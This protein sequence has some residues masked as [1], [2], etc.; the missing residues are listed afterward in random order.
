MRERIK[1]SPSAKIAKPR[2]SPTMTA[3]S[4][5]QRFSYTFTLGATTD[6]RNIW[7]S[8]F[9]RSTGANLQIVDFELYTGSS[10]LGPQVLAGHLYPGAHAYDTAPSYSGGVLDLT[11]SAFGAIQF[12]TAA[13][14][15]TVTAMAVA[16]KT[17]TGGS[18]FQVLLSKIQNYSDFLFETDQGGAAAGNLNDAK[19]MAQ[20]AGIY[21]PAGMGWHT[22]TLR[23]DGTYV[24]LFIDDVRLLR[25]TA[26]PSGAIS[27][28]DMFVNEINAAGLYGNL[29]FNSIA[30]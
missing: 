30:L 9:D 12:G 5:W 29:K 2:F 26:T 3:T 20:Y 15:S 4:A 17:A 24:D 16:E 14:L 25:A 28:A 8:S 23:V 11:N 19:V 22:F 13:S 1:N 18:G 27:L 7:L 10:D 21:E 6:I